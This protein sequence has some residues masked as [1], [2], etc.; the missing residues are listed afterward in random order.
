M[1]G[2]VRQLFMVPLVSRSLRL[3]HLNVVV[4]HEVVLSVALQEWMGMLEL[5]VLKLDHRMRPPG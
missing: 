1:A 4:P 3:P 5:E 2:D